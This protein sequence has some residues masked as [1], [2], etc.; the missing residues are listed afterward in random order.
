[1]P[2]ERPSS[3]VGSGSIAR[4]RRL[5]REGE[6]ILAANR[7]FLP[8]ASV[9]LVT[10]VKGSYCE[11]GA[12]LARVWTGS[13]VSVDWLLR[14]DGAARVGAK[15][16]SC[17]DKGASVVGIK[18]LLCEGERGAHR[19]SVD[20]AAPRSDSESLVKQYLDLVR[21]VLSKGTRKPNRTGVDTHL[22]VQRELRDRPPRGL[23]AP[24]D[25]GDLL[26]EHRRREPLVLERRDAHRPAQEARLQ[27][28]GPLGGRR[29]A[30]CRAPTA[31]SGAT[32]RCT[33]AAR[34]EAAR[35][36]QRSDSRGWPRRSSE[37]PPAGAS[38]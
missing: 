18:R 9:P 10:G 2:D 12:A 20:A 4:V 24:D 15:S 27:V 5:L 29:R 34:A 32:S 7:A 37:T 35:R 13:C 31:T 23:P 28:L 1:M 19:G 8:P 38:S 30:A 21:S 36:L 26:E 22:D 16:A 17:V 14:E 11:C 25:Q 33:R 3:S 6:A